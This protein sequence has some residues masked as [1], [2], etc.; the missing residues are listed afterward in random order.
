[1]SVRSLP[2]LDALG[3]DCIKS[4][5]EIHALLDDPACLCL[6]D[7]SPAE[8]GDE[9]GRFKVWAENIGALQ[10][11]G[12]RSSLEYRLRDASLARQQVLDFLE[13]L[14]ASLKEGTFNLQFKGLTDQSKMYCFG[15]TT[16]TI[17]RRLW[18]P[19]T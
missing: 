17:N 6:A 14:Q 7:M 5:K 10:P 2:V 19:P 9:L 13:D 4:F 12:M 3:H 15:R 11:R 16:S 18:I 8:V 1:M